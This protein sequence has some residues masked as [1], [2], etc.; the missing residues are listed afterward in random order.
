[1]EDSNCSMCRLFATVHAPNANDPKYEVDAYQLRAFEISSVLSDSQ[2]KIRILANP[3]VILGVLPVLRKNIII[4]STGQECLTRGFLAAIAPSD[5]PAARTRGFTTHLVDP[6][7]PNYDQI[8]KWIGQC[9]KQH[10]GICELDVPLPPTR[11]MCVDCS[12]GKVV[13]IKKGQEYFALSYVWGDT[14]RRNYSGQVDEVAGSLP[15][16]MIP[17]VVEDAMVVVE[18]LGG[19]YLWVDQFCINQEN[20]LEKHMQIQNMHR[21][22][23]GACATIVAVDGNNSAC[24]LP[25]VGPSVR[26]RQVSATYGRWRLAS[27]APHISLLLQQAPWTM[28]DEKSFTDSTYYDIGFARGLWW[29]KREKEEKRLWLRRIPNF[30]SWSW[31]G[32]AGAVLPQ[33]PNDVSNYELDSQCNYVCKDAFD[34]SFL[35]EL[36]NGQ[37]ISPKDFCGSSP[38][39]NLEVKLSRHLFCEADVV[40]VR[41]QSSQFVSDS[42]EEEGLVCVCSCHPD[43]PHERALNGPP[44]KRPETSSLSLFERPAGDDEFRR[45]F[46]ELWDCVVLFKTNSPYDCYKLLVI[47]WHGDTAYRIGSLSMQESI[48]NGLSR[49][50]QR[51]RLA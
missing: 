10:R 40:K 33:Y 11:L 4:V 9:Q 6:M 18:K 42:S 41:F 17:Q 45:L 14:G 32:W 13:Q 7:K 34:T 16:M 48:F 37:R 26:K 36:E 24:G 3:K 25:G 22:Y 27:I 49:T 2:R 12:T 5:R 38:D 29:E 50:R 31:A 8:R 28:R 47:D 15:V 35:L 43:A 51:V 23:E 30:P 44:L 21:I 20:A 39:A 19:R 46:D 1:M